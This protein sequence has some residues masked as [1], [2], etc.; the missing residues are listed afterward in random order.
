MLELEGAS[1]WPMDHQQMEPWQGSSQGAAMGD[2]SGYYYPAHES[3]DEFLRNWT[4][5]ASLH[6]GQ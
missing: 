1:P 3:W 2:M 4:Y 5:E 6:G